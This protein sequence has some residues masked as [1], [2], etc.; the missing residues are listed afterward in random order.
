ME[1]KVQSCCIT[2]STSNFC[3]TC[4]TVFHVL[5]AFS[6]ILSCWSGNIYCIDNDKIGTGNIQSH[7][8]EMKV[9]DTGL[10]YWREAPIEFTQLEHCFYFDCGKS[11]DQ[12]NQL[13][14]PQFFVKM[15]QVD[16]WSSTNMSVRQ[17]VCVSVS[18]CMYISVPPILA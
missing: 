3:S 2:H 9:Y 17:S 1:I 15:N 10:M 4:N 11:S 5:F 7:D 6:T 16:P 18:I 13:I 8:S 14:I 12:L